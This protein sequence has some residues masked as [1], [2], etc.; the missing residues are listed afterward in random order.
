MSSSFSREALRSVPLKLQSVD[1]G[2]QGPQRFMT[3][4]HLFIHAIRSSIQGPTEPRLAAALSQQLSADCLAHVLR[5]QYPTALLRPHLEGHVS[6]GVKRSQEAWRSAAGV[7]PSCRQ[8]ATQFST[9]HP[10]LLVHSLTNHYWV[11]TV[12]R[13]PCSGNSKVNRAF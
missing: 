8:V 2:D 7:S 1:P 4:H 5:S 10:G 6:A 12:C 11:S 13:V 9:G 3:S